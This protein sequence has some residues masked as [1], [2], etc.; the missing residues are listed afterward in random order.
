MRRAC[1]TSVGL[2]GGVFIA[3]QASAQWV[4]YVNETA[5]RLVAP[6]NLVVNDN[7]EKDFGMGDFNN[8]GRTDLMVMRKFPGS[9]QGGFENLLLM[10]ENGI[11]VDRT[12]EYGLDHDVPG[13]DL[14]MRAPTNDRNAHVVD[15][16]MDGWLDIVTATT[17]SDQV[18]TI[19]GQPRV[20]INKG[21]DGNGNWQG[22]RFE[23]QRIPQLFAKSGATA[24]PRFCDV[25]HG[26]VNGNGFPDLFFTD[27]DTP[28]T[29]GTVCIDL[30]GNGSTADPGECQQSPGQNPNLD[31][32]NRLLFN[33][34]NDG[35][36]GPGYFYDTRGSG[37]GFTNTQL[38]SAFG[39]AV[40]IVDLNGNGV[41]DIVRINTLTA[42]QNAA[43]FYNNVNDPGSSFTGP[44]TIYTGAPYHMA[45]GDLNNNGR[46]DLVIIDDSKDRWM[47]NNGNNGAGQATFT[48]FIIN[49]SLTEFG[50]TPRLADLDNDGLL[51]LMVPDVDADLPSFCPTTGR[52]AH[53][54]RN[55]GGPGSNDTFQ[56]IGQ[57]VPNNMLGATYD[58]AAMDLNN[59]G[60]LDLVI[61]RCAGIQIWRNVPPIF[62]EFEYPEGLPAFVDSGESTEL[63]VDLVITG[64]GSIVPGT[65]K[66]FVSVDGGP[67]VDSPLT[68]GSGSQWFAQLPA[69]DCGSTIS[70]YFSAD[71]S[72]G[73]LFTDPSTAPGNV[74]SVLAID[75]FELMVKEDFENGDGGWTM[76]NAGPVT[77]GAW[78]HAQPVGTITS[79]QVAAPFEQATPGGSWAWLTGVGVPGGSAG[80]TDLDGGPTVLVSAPFDLD[81]TDG[82]VSYARWFFGSTQSNPSAADQLVVQISNDGGDNWAV[83]EVIDTNAGQWVTSE[84]VAGAFV[85]P[86]ADMVVRFI[87]ADQPNNSIVEGGVDDFRVD[88]LVCGTKAPCLGDLDGN[89]S[90][91]GADLGLLL[92]AFG[93]KGGSAD[94]NGD[95]MVDGADLGL[96]LTAF[97]ACP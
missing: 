69:A 26:D 85:T 92:T 64:G 47:R 79:G 93:G 90:V 36:P 61:G 20:Y 73:G 6:P 75:E 37:Q 22:F 96:L 7:L 27:Y 32:D 10:N 43:V 87:I 55:T 63:E 3:S 17:M 9:I 80:A 44:V 25:D 71:L 48:T 14:G 91:D 45:A 59:N 8:N 77:G 33:W 40:S 97:G 84:F 5:T 39:N 81:G 65:A 4:T 42:G 2:L 95:G 70:Y 18:N 12:G 19:L 28:E 62:I 82:I 49:D 50:N 41:L 11:L 53:I 67:Y 16:N 72:N 88:A 58:F 1:L 54:Y 52:R 89:G 86:S 15:V 24:N 31:F 38:N 46:I 34:G 23:H 56:E 60:W 13:G 76:F 35:G 83:V 78:I 74:Y 66:V 21:N 30:N 51:D 94:L 68:P 29:S 57:I